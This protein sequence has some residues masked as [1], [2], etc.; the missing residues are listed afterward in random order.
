MLI[1]YRIDTDTYH[2]ECIT[3]TEAEVEAAGA[4]FDNQD[5]WDYYPT[6]EECKLE[7]DEV[8][9]TTD[10]VEWLNSTGRK[11]DWQSW[12]DAFR[13]VGGDHFQVTYA[14]KGQAYCLDCFIDT[15]LSGEQEKIK[16]FWQH[17][18]SEN[19]TIA[20]GVEDVITETTVQFEQWAGELIPLE[21]VDCVVCGA[22]LYA[23]AELSEEETEDP[24]AAEISEYERF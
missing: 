9:L 24:Q 17:M 12:N 20:D 6:C 14:N 19:I 23:A 22:E 21:G 16:L 11:A 8:Q 18:K 7:I 1:G 3:L 4:L 10:G 15:V 2:K 13:S 5:E